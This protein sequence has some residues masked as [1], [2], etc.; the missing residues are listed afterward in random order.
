MKALL[1]FSAITAIASTTLLA[2]RGPAKNYDP[3]LNKFIKMLSPEQSIAKI[4]LPPGYSLEPVLSEPH[5]TEPVDCVFDGNGR[6]Y[7]VQ[8]NTYMQDADGTDQFFKSSRITRHEDTNGDGKYD[9]HSTFV[10]ELML[11]RMLLPL[12]NGLV[13][14]T[15]NTNNLTLFRDT[16]GDGKADKSTLYFD[17]GKRGG[18]LEHQPSG[19]IWSIDNWVY[20][21]YNNKRY[22]LG[23]AQ[24][25]STEPTAANGGQWG[26]TQDNYGKPWYV[27]AG[28]EKGPVNFQ[29]PNLY[30]TSSHFKNQTEKNF[31]EVYPICPIPD[32]QGGPKRLKSLE[33]GGE[34]LNHFTATCGPDIFRGDRLPAD[35]RG[36]LLFAEPVGRLIRRADITINDGVTTLSNAHPKS[37]F[38]RSTDPNFRP[39]NMTTAPDGTL[40]IVDMYRGIIQEG[41]WTKPGSYL[42]TVI[43]QYGLDKNIQHGR[44][45]RL[46]HKD[47]KPGPMPKMIDAKSSELVKHL[48]HPNGWWRDTAQKILVLRKDKTVE[49][50]LS[51]LLLEDNH[52][53]RIHALWTLDGTGS[54]TANHVKTTLEDNHPAVVRAA[55]RAAESLIKSKHYA[56]S[57]FKKMISSHINH[58]DSEVVMQVLLTANLHKFDNLGDLQK[59]ASSNPSAGV[60]QTLDS[61]LTKKK[62]IASSLPKELKA[63]YKR[64]ETIYQQLCTSCH[65][66]NGKGVDVGGSPLAPPLAGSASV[67]GHKDQAIQILLHGLEGPVAGKSYT[68]PMLSMKSQDDQW[69]ADVISYI[70]HGLGNRAGFVAPEDVTKVRAISKGRSEYWTLKELEKT[71]P[72]K[73]DKSRWKVTVSNNKKDA[74]LAIDN[75][76]KTRYTTASRQNPGMW[77]QIEFPK[78]IMLSSVRLD[79]TRSPG[80]FPDSYIAEVSLDGQ[81]WKQ[82]QRP[83]KG[84]HAITEISFP[85]TQAK[86]FRV[87][88]R[89]TKRLYWSIHEIEAFGK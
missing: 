75:K 41:N 4:Q 10:D 80:D 42:R 88:T 63:Q 40:Y 72:Q 77:M 11:P 22:K 37:E 8:M 83:I 70:R 14:G 1:R 84:T 56:S 58:T 3:T 52:L 34:V 36:D 18:N 47:F 20:T 76:D 53:T 62:D 5:I 25:I 33:G 81:N 26:L 39:V 67:N 51:K 69:I 57:S 27:N 54:L 86:F 50:Q 55:I 45:Y 13:V 29:Y 64:G 2:Q 89:S 87:T 32:V 6:M 49:A 30:G 60:S 19:L 43:D 38:I 23:S 48:K 66:P 61:M 82:V 85:S 59:T 16:T 79:T 21:T 28:G 65:G 17:G 9:K 7:V 71:V 31:K 68:Q 15:T 78:K 12:E 74:A 24:L 73:L 35:I 44:I 46:V